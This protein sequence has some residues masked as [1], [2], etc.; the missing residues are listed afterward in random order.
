MNFCRPSS[1]GNGISLIS[2]WPGDLPRGVQV[3]QGLSEVE[4]QRTSS[5][6]YRTLCAM[7]LPIPLS[8]PTKEISGHCEIYNISSDDENIRVQFKENSYLSIGRNDAPCPAP[9]P[10]L[11]GGEPHSPRGNQVEAGSFW[12]R[13]ERK[14]S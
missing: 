7:T 5:W 3:G 12:K 10:D 11:K 8:G 6:M 4:P 9:H 1:F 14:A 13:K 2:Y